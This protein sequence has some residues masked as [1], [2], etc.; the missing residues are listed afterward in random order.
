MCWSSKDGHCIG[1]PVTSR[2]GI[3]LHKRN[4]TEY[5]LVNTY[6]T[7]VGLEP[8]HPNYRLELGARLLIFVVPV[9]L[10]LISF[11]LFILYHQGLISAFF[12]GGKLIFSAFLIGLIFSPFVMLI[13]Y[14]A[15]TLRS[16]IRF[17][18]AMANIGI[19]AAYI[20]SMPLWFTGL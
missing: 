4:H 20:L 8:T 10:N 18:Y 13:M 3:T 11:C 14:T 12:I 2:S 5:E 16:D 1:L 17:K 9:I 7:T 15:R 19:T 6:W